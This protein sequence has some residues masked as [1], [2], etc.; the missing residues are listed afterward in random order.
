MAT[1]QAAI[2][3]AA[4]QDKA[5]KTLDNL[6]SGGKDV[7]ATLAAPSGSTVNVTIGTSGSTYVAPKNGWLV[8]RRRVSTAGNAVELR[9]ESMGMNSRVFGAANNNL[10]AIYLPAKKGQTIKYQYDGTNTSDQSLFFVY[11]QGEV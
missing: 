10:I 5:N 11:A 8:F 2:A 1:Q 7:I 9:N 3:T 6:T 4:V